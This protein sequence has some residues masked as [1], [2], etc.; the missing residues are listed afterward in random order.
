[1]LNNKWYN[2]LK[3]IAQI[4]LP[5]LGTFYFTLGDLWNFPNVAQVVGTIMAIDT[6]LGV[7]L[8]LSSVQYNKVGGKYAGAINL[9]WNPNPEAGGPAKVFMLELAEPAVNL[10]NETEVSLKVNNN[11]QR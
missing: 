3:F 8:G 7:L 2:V 1:M 5:G 6:F 11:L 4:A 10:E 9:E